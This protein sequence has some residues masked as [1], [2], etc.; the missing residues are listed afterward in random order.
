MNRRGFLIGLGALLAAPAVVRAGSLMQIKGVVA[1]PR[2]PYANISMPM[3]LDD[4]RE[5]ILKPAISLYCNSNVFIKNVEPDELFNSARR[6][7]LNKQ[8]SLKDMEE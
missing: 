8:Y 4:Y 1:L 3:T 7:Y 2:D 6:C 5:R